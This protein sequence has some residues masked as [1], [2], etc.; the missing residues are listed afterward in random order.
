MRIFGLI[1][2]VNELGY[3]GINNQLIS[4]NK[5]DMQHFKNVTKNNIVV[6]GYNTYLSMNLK[7]LSNR[8]NI[9]FTNKSIKNT[10]DVVFTNKVEDIIELAKYADIWVIGGN[11]IY[12]LFKDYYNTLYI[13]TTK[14]RIV[15]DIM[16]P[17]IPLENFKQLKIYEDK[18]IIINKWI[19][20][21]YILTEKMLFTTKKEN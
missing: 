19:N 21:K 5:V 6:M 13:T 20:T 14:N 7:P 9:V 18:N 16:F 4:Y 10:N 2:N 15:G 12:N 11:S 8:F 17:D 1:A 3:I